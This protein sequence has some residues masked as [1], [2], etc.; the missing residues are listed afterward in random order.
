MRLNGTQRTNIAIGIAHGMKYLHAN[1][2]IH[3]DLKSANVLLDAKMLARVADF[4]L[5]KFMDSGPEVT[6]ATGTVQW[7]A[8]EQV[9]TPDYG[10]P[11]DVFSY[12]MVLFE[13]LTEKIPYEGLAVPAIYQILRKGNRPIIQAEFMGHP[14]SDLIY[15][16]WSEDPA[17][18][19]TF[20]Q[21]CEMFEDELV[22]FPHSNPVG[23]R[24]LLAQIERQQ[25]EHALLPDPTIWGEPVDT[26]VDHLAAL[27]DAAEAGDVRRFTEHFISSGQTDVNVADPARGTALH[28]AVRENELQMVAFLC[29]LHG[30]DVNAA[31]PGGI[32]PLQ[33]AK[34][35]GRGA[36]E[37]LMLERNGPV[38]NGAPTQ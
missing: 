33:L 14:I 27:L 7:M 13:L 25:Q 38:G 30:I 19:P 2:I 9:F 11:A 10:P 23:V 29:Q 24:R 15:K 16:C 1:D 22:A 20:E 35:Q 8:P 34:E 4:G 12:G 18:R 6:R 5:G 28:C 17:M 36:A 37:R 26:T 3:R 31:G 21:I 32:T